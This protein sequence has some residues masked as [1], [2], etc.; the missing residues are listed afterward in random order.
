MKHPYLAKLVFPLLCAGV[1]V[2]SAYA[3]G[4]GTV[5]GRILD[6]KNEGMPGVTVLIEGTTFGGSTNSDG[7]F[8]IQGVP[9][10]QHTLVMSFVGYTT[11]RQTIAVT[12]GQNTTVAPTAL[13]ENTTLL[14]EAVVVGYGTQ[15][16]QDLTGAVEQISE[17]QFVK[18][19][20]TNPEQLVQGKV[21][22]V[23]ITTGGGAPGAGSQILIRGGS[24]LS[25]SNSPLIIIDGVPVDNTGLAGASNPLSLINPNDIESITVL[26]DASSTAIYGV[27]A[28]NGVILVTTKKGVQGDTFHVNVSTQQS[29]ATVAKYADVL[30]AD[31]FRRL[32][33]E[34]GTASQL[35]TLGTANTDWQKEIYRTAYTADNNVSISGSA[36]PVPYRVSGGYL[37]QQGLLKNNDL[38]RY[39][40]AISLTPVLLNGNLRATINL[41]GSWIDNNFSN[42]G[43]VGAAV[44]F[45]P[46]QPVRVNGS[47]GNPS[48]LSPGQLGTYGGYT[49]FANL[50]KDGN[51]VLNTLAPRN[52]VGLINQRRDRSTVKRSI[53]NIQLDYK[54]PFLTG[55]SANVNLGYDIQRGDGTTFVPANAGSDFNR[56]G[57]NNN[58]SQDLNNSLLEAY[59]KYERTL[60]IG[61]LE[62]L[63]GY[64]YQKFENRTYVFNNYRAD[65]SIF[66]PV[67]LSY[68]GQDTYLNRNVLVGFYGRLNYN[69][70]DKYLFTGTFRADGTSRFSPDHFGYFPSGAFAWRVKGEDFLK[71]SEAISE[72]KV[73]LGYGQ[74][75]QQD[76]GGNYYPFLAN[77]TYGSLTA[78]Y[79]LGDTFYRTLRSD[80][81]NPNITWE[82]TTTYNAGID[83]GFFGGRFYGSVDVYKRD[84]RDL[85]NFVNI[86]ALSGLSNAG[87]FNVGSLTN[88]GIEVIANVDA[89]KGDDFNVTVNGN[90]TYNQNRIT[91]LNTVSSANDVGNLTGGIAG[92]AGNTIQVNSV[93]YA[94]QS[95]YVN[96]QVYGANGKPLE[97]VY[98]D[99]NGDGSINSS[100][101]YRYKSA[102]PDYI[103]GGGANLSYRGANLAFTLR[104]NIGNY[105]Y[106]N[107]ASEAFYDQSTTGFVVNRNR[108]VLRS[109]FNSAQYFSDY[110]VENASFLRMEN[111]TLGYNFG[112]LV[113]KG[114]NLSLSFAVQNVFLITKYN[115]IDP[116]IY[117]AGTAGAPATVGI[118]NAI[119]PRPRTFTVGLNLG[120]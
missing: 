6:E 52:P 50:D 74:T 32:T 34:R 115:G 95:F 88:K 103:I 8:S 16:R 78:Q 119:Y 110:F 29:L 118:D 62:L 100:D 108:E 114:T 51:L 37:A 4:V 30:S 106:N 65:R 68:T 98:V 54:L 96:Q 27:R 17:K 7:T 59:A 46:T 1:S 71:N 112:E 60:G 47:E 56:Q 42:Q 111:V 80:Q 113:R 99:R 58:Y 44:A 79:Q 70:A 13:A 67:S 86:P 92:G 57:L 9:A 19:Q 21:A 73:R 53:G 64:S 5:S 81:Y 18:G 22:G 76:L 97:G 107:R 85:L 102:R 26:K 75:G 94:A 14:N 28:S 69:I 3:Q 63:A 72:L 49:E 120:I 40:G 117:N 93:G 61:R 31:E 38:K 89:V 39:S 25:A 66:E 11:R 43:A 15:R 109:N 48:G 82:T 84:T 87:T 77:L 41:K 90:L 35:S 10:G 36:G 105:V 91:K 20:V 83:Y 2:S 104:S 23:Q 24:S 101:R 12:A 33:Q 45:D 116:E 55:L